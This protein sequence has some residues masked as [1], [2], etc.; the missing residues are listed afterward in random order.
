MRT[1]LDHVKLTSRDVVA[2]YGSGT[3]NVVLQVC[4]DKCEGLKLA[5]NCGG[6]S[7]RK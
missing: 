5:I 4:G 1:I 2:D 7:A 6:V 3:G